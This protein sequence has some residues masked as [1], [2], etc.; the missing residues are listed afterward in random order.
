MGLLS[1]FGASPETEKSFTQGLLSIPMAFPRIRE[2]A[3]REQEAATEAEWKK[4]QREMQEAQYKQT[5]DDRARTMNDDTLIQRLY[6]MPTE[7][8]MP[9]GQAGPGMPMP[10]AG[11]DPQTFLRQGGT[12]GGLSKAAE[13]QKALMPAK[14]DSPFGNV[15]PGDFTPE[16]LSRFAQSRNFGDLVPMQ[17]PQADDEFTRILKGAGI[18][19]ASPQGQ[20][21][22]KQYAE[23][24]VAPPQGIQIG[25]MSPVAGM[26][27]GQPT[28][29]QPPNRPGAQ[30][31]PLMV[32]GKPVRPMP[33]GGGMPTEDE[34]KAAGW[35][36]QA[37]N[38][39]GNMLKALKD[40][41]GAAAKPNIALEMTRRIPF[42]GEPLA[43]RSTSD[44][45]QRFEQAASSFSEAALR[46]ATGA[47]V[48]AQEA[49]QKIKELT[50]QWGDKEGTIAQKANAMTVY[51]NALKTRAGR[52]AV[53]EP[54]AG[55][56]NV[57][58]DY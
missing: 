37:N 8:A 14:A 41:G 26:V 50:P 28:M 51:L 47:G 38:A 42:V 49:A 39:Y 40:S 12:I 34:R 33:A 27:D 24:K 19:P 20:A 30:T 56:Q 52:A 45:R 7:G 4:R 25:L 22:F 32:N 18:D 11:I 48:N 58:V 44:A 6:G 54:S 31:V 3:M 5:Q 36:D 17:K 9:Q 15:N 23:R 13:V 10:N 21:L 55:G 53:Q 35:F 1:M 16:S 29:V 43:N 46:A 57:T 2:R